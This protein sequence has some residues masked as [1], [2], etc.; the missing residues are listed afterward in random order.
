MATSATIHS[1]APQ[2]F[3]RKYI[4]SLDHKVIG[5]QYYFLALVAV[6][7]GMF[8]SISD[9]GSHDLADGGFA[10]RRRDQARNL[11]EPA[12]HARHDHGVLRLDHGATGWVRKLFF[13]HPDWGAGYGVSS[14]E[15]AFVLDDVRGLCNHPGC[16]LCDGW[17]SAA[18]LDRLCSAECAD[19]LPARANNWARICGSRALRSFASRR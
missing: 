11:L 16:V 19:Q 7:V 6:F 8:L 9:A 5:L 2:G 1:H 17:S 15:H 13:A 10:A 12:D 3:I 14:L 18:W 4:F